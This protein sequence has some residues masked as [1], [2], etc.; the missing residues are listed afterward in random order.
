MGIYVVP[1][2]AAPFGVAEIVRICFHERL[3]A[4]ANAIVG[5]F[6]PLRR[7]IVELLG[8]SGQFDYLE[9]VAEYAP[10]DLYALDNIGRATNMVSQLDGTSSLRCLARAAFAS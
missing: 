4:I 7:T 10:Y 1:I 2:A 9:F 3:N 6:G 5:G 8:Y